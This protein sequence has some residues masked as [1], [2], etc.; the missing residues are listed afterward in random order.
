MQTGLLAG[1][2]HIGPP[3]PGITGLFRRQAGEWRCL[4]DDLQCFNLFPYPAGG[5][6]ILAGTSHGVYRSV[7]RGVTFSRAEFPDPGR[8]IWCFQ[9]DV[10]DANVVYAGAAPAGFYRSDDRGAHWIRL[11]DPDVTVH[12]PNDYFGVRVLRLSQS[13]DGSELYAA[14]EING[15]LRSR[16]GG[17]TWVDI[18]PGLVRLAAEHPHLRS[19]VAQDRNFAEGMLDAHAV[20]AGEPGAAIIALRMGL[21]RTED[22]GATWTDMEVGRFSPNTYARDLRVVPGEPRT[23]YAAISVSA[24]GEHGALYRSRDGGCT[25]ARF[26][27]VQA[28]S[29]VMSIALHPRD[30]A[31]VYFGASAHGEIR[32]TADGGVTWRDFS[33]PAGVA[34][35]YCVACC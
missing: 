9:V 21:F 11:P 20:V 3:G 18:S 4:L 27:A 6:I 26:G 31:R 5:D 25:W 1:T 12:C 2:G 23:L 16:D 15:A 14:L 7:D 32:G 33:L 22:G 24:T 30:P 29:T 13:T 19:M 10:R 28:G 17:R 34:G 35:V 8:E